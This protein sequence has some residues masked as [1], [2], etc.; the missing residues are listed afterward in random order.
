MP[1]NKGDEAV[2]AQARSGKARSAGH[3]PSLAPRSLSLALG[4]SSQMSESPEAIRRE[5]AQQSTES[6]VSILRNRDED[7]WRPE[8]FDIVAA[9]LRERGVSPADVT[10]LGPEDVAVLESEPTVTLA[11]F[12]SPAHAHSCKGALEDAGLKAWVVDEALGTIY[13]L[14]V[15]TRVQVRQED[16]EAAQ[17]VVEGLEERPLTGDALPPDLAE[18]P[19][20]SCGSTK[21]TQFIDVTDH[22]WKYRCTECANAWSED[23]EIA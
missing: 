4:E 2:G 5:L 20:P 14:G 10:A 16:L 17:A 21:V 11:T 6:L 18:P 8:V 9:I 12:F 22:R 13:A 15:G 23:D 7:Q 19:C 3:R 1:S